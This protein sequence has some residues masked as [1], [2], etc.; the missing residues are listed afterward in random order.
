MICKRVN[1]VGFLVKYRR[2]Y[3]FQ[4]HIKILFFYFWYPI[5]EVYYKYSKFNNNAP[6]KGPVRLPQIFSQD[7]SFIP[8]DLKKKFSV[9]FNSAQAGLSNIDLFGSK[10]VFLNWSFVSVYLFT[11]VLAWNLLILE[12]KLLWIFTLNTWN[13][14]IFDKPI[15]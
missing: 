14:T 12:K 2:D 11:L 15:L 10:I 8:L 1:K 6:I 9:V 13:Q 7:Q 3:P 5:E 4:H